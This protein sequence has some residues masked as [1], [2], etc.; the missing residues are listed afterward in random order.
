VMGPAPTVRVGKIVIMPAA[1]FPA[2]S[3]R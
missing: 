1:V 2:A 3:G